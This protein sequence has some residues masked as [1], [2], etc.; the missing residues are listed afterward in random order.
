MNGMKK[1]LIALDYNPSAEKIAEAGYALAKATN[2]AVILMHVVADPVYY[3]N[4]D[5]SPIM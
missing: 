3:S 2:A 1:I 5:Y 4:L